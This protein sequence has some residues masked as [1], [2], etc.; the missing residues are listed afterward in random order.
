M[1]YIMTL[2]IFEKKGINVP[3]ID[4]ADKH[5]NSA[6]IA[7]F[8]NNK[9]DWYVVVGD[10]LENGD[11]LFFGLVNGLYKELGTFTLSQLENVL[12]F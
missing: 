7:K 9:W 8:T 3:S 12:L 1:D 2:D 4:D 11:Y 6:I 5:D 10:K